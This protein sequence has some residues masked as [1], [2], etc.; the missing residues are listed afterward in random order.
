MGDGTGTTGMTGRID[1]ECDPNR[2]AARDCRQ[3]RRAT[4]T[5][6]AW[7]GAFAL[8]ALASN[9]IE[10]V[11]GDGRYATVMVASA[12]I[13]LVSCAVGAVVSA[14]CP[15]LREVGRAAYLVAFIVLLACCLAQVAGV[16]VLSPHDFP[17]VIGGGAA[18]TAVLAV[19]V[20]WMLLHDSKASASGSRAFA[21]IEGDILM[22]AK[23]ELRTGAADGRKPCWRAYLV[24]LSASD[25][26]RG[27]APMFLRDEWEESIE[28]RGGVRRAW[29]PGDDPAGATLPD[30]DEAEPV[31]AL[32]IPDVLVPD[33]AGA[34]ARRGA[35][36]VEIP[37]PVVASRAGDETRG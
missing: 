32:C 4:A 12:A 1:F 35:D 6:V 16:A 28:M 31:R 9:R 18:A 23:K 2:A 20:R 24:P 7:G 27:E 19:A 29:L 21:R 22:Y 15:R 26:G 8:A 11:A 34:L 37:G 13:V 14:G 36:V 5:C 33:L 30:F 25:A 3:R 10:T 17:F